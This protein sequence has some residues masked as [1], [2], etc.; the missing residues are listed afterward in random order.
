MTEP[1]GSDGVAGHARLAGWLVLVW[2]LL[3][4]LTSTVIAAAGE[5]KDALDALLD[6]DGTVEW[7]Q[8]GML[9]AA[10]ALLGSGRSALHRALALCATIA[11]FRELDG[12]LA[13]HVRPGSHGVAM[14][15]V[16][17]VLVLHAWRA[18]ERLGA[19]ATAFFRRPGFVLMACGFVA[20][21]VMAQ[22]LGQ[23]DLWHELS[24]PHL[25]GA[26]KRV[27][28]EGL[29]GAGYLMVLAGAVEERLF[30]SRSS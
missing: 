23:R 11:V 3:W 9:A 26:S 29:E 27:V 19:E 13:D 5:G 14:G 7:M 22:L 17:V 6:D 18:R 20:V 21:A 30:R 4:W 10:A 15:L 2:L 12:F 24:R 28:E 1:R 25:L 16:G 8:V